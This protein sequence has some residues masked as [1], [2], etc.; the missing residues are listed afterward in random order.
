MKRSVS[1]LKG[2]EQHYQTNSVFKFLALTFFP[3][4]GKLFFYTYICTESP[5]STLS[6]SVG[7]L[8]HQV[9]KSAEV[10]GF[11]ATNSTQKPMVHL[12][13]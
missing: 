11:L 7:V 6:G 9:L 10:T 2:Q 12:H 13:W 4:R 1:G 3:K 8:R 5:K